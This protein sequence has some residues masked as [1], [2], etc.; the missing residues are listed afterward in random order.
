MV[1]SRVVLKSD[2]PEII[3][4][5]GDIK[6]WSVSNEVEHTLYNEL[7]T[8]YMT[9]QPMLTP[10]VE[11]ATEPF[12]MAMAQAY[13]HG[14][15]N[16]AIEKTAYDIEAGCKMRSRVDTGQMMNGWTAEEDTAAGLLL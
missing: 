7:G 8:I 1:E 9:A 2:L 11:E 5:N 6:P 14:M 3:A 12:K 15:V 10:S 13:T 16:S 4:A